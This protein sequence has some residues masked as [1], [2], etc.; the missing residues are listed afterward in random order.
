MVSVIIPTFN[1][2]RL[3][4]EAIASALAQE[5]VEFELIVVDDGSGDDT[6]S[7]LAAFGIAIRSV[8]QPH[9]GVSAARNKG[10][11]EAKGEW[12][13]FLDSDDLW[14]PQKLRLQLDFFRKHPD[15]RICQ[16]EEIWIRHGRKL[17][18]KSY[19]QKPQGYCFAKLLERCLISP[20]AV[21]IHR[22]LL[23]EVGFFDE[24]MPACEDYDL[25]LRIGCR[26]PIGLVQEPLT[27]KRGGHPDQ[28]SSTIPALDR[29]RILALAKLLR[30]E[31]LNTEQQEEVLRVLALKCRI[32]GE[33][34]RKRERK[35]E[36]EAFQRLPEEL[37]RRLNLR[38]P[39]VET[40]PLVVR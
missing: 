37:A 3:V 34:C 2:C 4:G 28:L 16:T 1:R 9:G 31:P 5:E 11:R 6:A 24:S 39:P 27:V 40:W 14:L 19:H 30:T 20:S 23:D 38:R 10:I 15:F 26:Y 7:A 35:A 32:Y 21:V 25:W 29:Y 22:G 13:A 33:G 36:A 17:N 18:P 12:L 8:F